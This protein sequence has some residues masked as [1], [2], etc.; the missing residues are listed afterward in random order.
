MKSLTD[1]MSIGT[2]AK[3]SGLTPRQ[4]RYLEERN[5]IKPIYIDVNGQRQRRYTRQ[6][7]DIMAYIAKLR[8]EGYEIT[9]AVKL[10]YNQGGVCYE[11]E[12]TGSVL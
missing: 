9:T 10:S 11:D 3:I 12:G 8:S 6:Q 7:V 4:I 5:Y 2:A 1:T